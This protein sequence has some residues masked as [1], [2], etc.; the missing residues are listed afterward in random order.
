MT[1]RAADEWHPT[2]VLHGAGDT[3]YGVCH[4]KHCGWVG[5]TLPRQEAVADAELHADTAGH[6]TGL[7]AMV[8]AP[9]PPRQ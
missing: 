9:Q 7:A 6:H 4:L 1:V 8:I 5:Q 2:E 3:A